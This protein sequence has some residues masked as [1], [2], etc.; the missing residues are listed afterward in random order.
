MHTLQVRTL[1]FELS[2][3]TKSATLDGVFPSV[4]EL[5]TEFGL[6]CPELDKLGRAAYGAYTA[7]RE[8]TE[9]LHAEVVKIRN[10]YAM[11][12]RTRVRKEKKVHAQDERVREAILDELMAEDP[13]LANLN[14][15]VSVCEDALQS[16]GVLFADGD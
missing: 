4:F 15:I 1:S 12:E 3:P 8:Q 9:H 11:R 14:R 6:S 13:V 5:K 16:D 2:S 7:S 10:L